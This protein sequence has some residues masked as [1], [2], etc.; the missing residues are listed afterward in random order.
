[1]KE[2]VWTWIISWNMRTFA[3][4]QV[5]VRGAGELGSGIAHLLHRVGFSVFISEISQP[6]AIR[7]PVCFSDAII[8]GESEVHNVL[9]KFYGDI[10]T[11]GSEATDHIPVYRD[12][13]RKLQ[14]L[15][16]SILI[17]ARM[18][19]Q[20]DQDFRSMAELMIGLGPGFDTATNCNLVIETKRGHDLG[21]IISS[22]SATTN[23][24]I[25]GSIGGETIN[26]LIKAPATGR[27]KWEVG[28]GELVSKGQQLGSINKSSPIVAPLDGMM[29][30][31]ISPA[32][33]VTTHMKIGDVDP[34]GKEVNHLH[35][36]E[37]TRM[38]ALAVLEAIILHNKNNSHHD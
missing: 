21:R 26:R 3:D 18:I 8:D 35:I 25:P 4:T 28:F 2:S 29:R 17:D 23:S 22:G 34:R 10:T 36:S 6:L 20:Y 37:K 38:I 19:K 16:A 5:W 31:M 30:G 15:N 7:R 11:R 13:P 24:G 33:E 1:M 32:T 9:A 12:H 27:V 14:K